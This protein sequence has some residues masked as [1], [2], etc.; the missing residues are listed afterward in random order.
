MNADMFVIH[1]QFTS[2]DQVI[3]QE[4]DT[5]Q[6][7][8]LKALNGILQPCVE[9]QAKISRDL[10]TLK[11]GMIASILILTIVAVAGVLLMSSYATLRTTGVIVFSGGSGLAI[12][13]VLLGQKR[14]STL[15]G[16]IKAIKP[17]KTITSMKKLRLPFYLYNLGSEGHLIADGAGLFPQIQVSFKNAK[18]KTLTE[19]GYHEFNERFSFLN[20]MMA[21]PSKKDYEEIMNDPESAK[22]VKTRL[23]ETILKK[24]IEIIDASLDGPNLEEILISFNALK[25]DDPF[26][27]EIITLLLQGVFHDTLDDPLR[28]IEMQRDRDMILRQDIVEIEDAIMNLTAWAG[29]IIAGRFPEFLEEIG[30]EMRDKVAIF[31]RRMDITSEFMQK[32]FHRDPQLFEHF[33]SFVFCD[34]PDCRGSNYNKNVSALD[35]KGYLENSILVGA[36]TQQPFLLESGKDEA[37]R[38]IVSKYKG[39]VEG[40]IDHLPQLVHVHPTTVGISGD[41][42]PVLV[43]NVVEAVPRLAPG[44][45]Y[46]WV[47]PKCK[48]DAVLLVN[49]TIEP[50]AF[51]YMDKARELKEKV[52]DL[53]HTINSNMQA[54]INTANTRRT[55]IGPVEMAYKDAKMKTLETKYEMEEAENILEE[56]RKIS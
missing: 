15:Y 49:R 10:R 22:A 31:K 53:R 51:Y 16:K 13:V 46:D 48:G 32:T 34:N 17:R 52:A 14:S 25:A 8:Y 33:N 45:H 2:N 43:S 36:T 20:S 41:A 7:A 42:F 4:D 37:I 26:F 47:C 54:V 30:K 24:P 39:V 19:N 55:A 21:M 38:P 23:I 50:L 11:K 18:N 12:L 1:P 40:E 3:D 35:M 56:L 29:F 27:N 44:G 9:E 6:L 28:F 5:M